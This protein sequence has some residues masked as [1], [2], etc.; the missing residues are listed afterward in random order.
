MIANSGSDE[1]GKISGGQAG[2][3]T[4]NEWRVRSWYNR[5]WKCVLRYPVE[6]I[7]NDI[8]T[9]AEHG[10]A[11]DHVGYDQSQRLTFWEALSK[12]ANYD[13]AN[14]TID[15][16]EDCS[17]GVAAI[18]KAVGYR[19]GLSKLRDVN[20]SCYT[21]NLR[22]VLK[23]AGFEVLTESKY[24]TSDKYL[25]RGDILLND[26][27][28]T[29]INL[30]NG[31]MSGSAS[32]TSTS[33]GGEKVFYFGH[34]RK[35]KTGTAV[36]MFQCVANVRFGYNL[37]LDGS[38]GPATEKAIREIQAKLGLEQDGSCGPATWTAIL[39]A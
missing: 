5:P 11:N 36:L 6:A 37:A 33:T 4:G 38:C 14:I 16:E 1:H 27:A 12:A 25:K 26:S 8:A 15:C 22:A 2:D 35:G 9:L 21:G 32:A 3:Q 19:N 13:P 24:L 30:S 18:V 23:A 31:S 7:R 29:A 28:H 39:A 10:A 20:A 17:S 34:V